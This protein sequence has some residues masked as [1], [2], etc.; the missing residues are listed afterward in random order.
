MKSR[1]VLHSYIQKADGNKDHIMKIIFS[2]EEQTMDNNKDNKN[3]SEKKLDSCQVNVVEQSEKQIAFSQI[4]I[5]FWKLS[6]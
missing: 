2:K 6:N 1:R 4:A 3:L 5:E